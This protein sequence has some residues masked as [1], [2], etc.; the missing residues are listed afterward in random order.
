MLENFSVGRFSLCYVG[1]ELSA[2]KVCAWCLLPFVLIACSG[3]GGE[4]KEDVAVPPSSPPTA[5][6]TPAP[7]VVSSPSPTP[8]PLAS[9]QPEPT[10]QPEPT[11]EPEPTATPTPLSTASPTPTSSINQQI[12]AADI[13]DFDLETLHT[14]QAKTGWYT[15]SWANALAYD[16]ESTYFVYV[17]A[18]LKPHVG[19]LDEQ[20]SVQEQL[21]ESD[22]KAVDDGHNEFSIALD[23]Q[24]FI[25]IV[26]DMHN[27]SLR[28]WRS[29]KPRDISGFTRFDQAIPNTSFTYYTFHKDRNGLLYLSA[30]VQTLDKYYVRGGRGVG[31]FRYDVN[32]QSWQVLGALPDHPDAV[33]PVVFWQN[34]GQNGGSYQMY[35]T[36]VL[37]DRDNVLHLAFMVNTDDAA[38]RHN[39]AVYAK[40][41]DGG[42]SFVG[43]DNRP[44]S[45]PMQ[46]GQGA[47]SPDVLAGYENADLSEHASM[48]IDRSNRLAVYFAQDGETFYRYSQA[49]DGSDPDL[50]A[51]VAALDAR[52]ALSWSEPK[53]FLSWE[54]ERCRPL[55]SEAAGLFLIADGQNL[56]YGN[57]VEQTFRSK[58][59]SSKVLRWDLDRAQ[60]Q[61]EFY[62][63]SWS[64]TSGSW[65]LHRLKINR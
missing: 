10:Q 16:G 53:A 49:R 38:N 43:I 51:D 14:V 23:S 13:R 25:H 44:L 55:Y 5:S 17:D 29:N 54:C 61:N 59:L 4:R 40:S 20:D 36:D 34:S 19:A 48:F 37:F 24:G 26:G 1:R 41:L 65:S 62:G 63:V 33:F 32:D 22:Y 39:Y 52:Q 60:Y 7:T 9:L 15:D 45:L 18:D 6:T 30:R 35:K 56:H 47:A 31:L 2:L 3:S 64:S 8:T 27:N 46:L 28:Y 58:A 57:S 21:L 12:E 11:S 42:E 50:S